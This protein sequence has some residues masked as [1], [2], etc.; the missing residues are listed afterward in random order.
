MPK[1]SANN[2]TMNSGGSAVPQ[3]EARRQC[4][5][6]A[7]VAVRETGLMWANMLRAFQVGKALTSDGEPSDHSTVR[8]VDCQQL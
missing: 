2:I 8:P 4:Q 3:R 7:L 6:A 5:P 1:A